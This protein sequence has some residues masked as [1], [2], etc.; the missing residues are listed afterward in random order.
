MVSQNNILYA[1][2]T[3]T[4]LAGIMGLVAW[5]QTRKIV[6]ITPKDAETTPEEPSSEEVESSD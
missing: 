3:V 1:G 6:P 5:K 4:F 2:L